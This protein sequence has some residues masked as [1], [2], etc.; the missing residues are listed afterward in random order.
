MRET[1]LPAGQDGVLPGHD[2]GSKM[3]LQASKQWQAFNNSAPALTLTLQVQLCPARHMHH[4]AKLIL[5]VCDHDASGK[6]VTALNRL[7][8]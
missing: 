1:Y 6:P 4:N 5:Q 2:I 7:C 3:E 8:A